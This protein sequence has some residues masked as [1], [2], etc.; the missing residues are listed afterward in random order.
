MPYPDKPKMK[1]PFVVENIDEEFQQINFTG[2]DTDWENL[3]KF[4][5]IYQYAGNSKDWPGRGILS[6]DPR[7]EFNEV[8]SWVTAHEK[9]RKMQ[10]SFKK[11]DSSEPLP[12]FRILEV[13]RTMGYIRFYS[14]DEDAYRFV[15]FGRI[16][17]ADAPGVFKLY[18]NGD[19]SFT[20][21]LRYMET[22]E[23]Y[24]KPSKVYCPRCA[25]EISVGF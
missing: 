2:D 6:V 22:I 17:L 15:E 24:L 21:I 16:D 14:K 5:V 13:N 8:V 4:G 9:V 12:P 23:S 25:T 19:R 3:Q 10:K 11:K 20:S 18:P 7:Y 1:S